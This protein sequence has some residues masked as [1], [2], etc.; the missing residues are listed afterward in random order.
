MTEKAIETGICDQMDCES[1]I[2][3][4]TDC[5]D[6]YL[7][8]MLI[9][10]QFSIERRWMTNAFIRIFVVQKLECS[11]PTSYNSLTSATNAYIH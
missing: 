2:C 11:G 7:A 4:H 8:W 5:L 10:K 1:G 9:N 6:L 3:D